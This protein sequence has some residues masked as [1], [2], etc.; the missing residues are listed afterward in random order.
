MLRSISN[1]TIVVATD[2]SSPDQAAAGWGVAVVDASHIERQEEFQIAT[3]HEEVGGHDQTSYMAEL[4]AV[5]RVTWAAMLA[6]KDMVLMIDNRVVSELT[7]DAFNGKPRFPHYGFGHIADIAKYAKR[8]KHQV[9]WIPSHG[10]NADWKPTIEVT[11]Q[12]KRER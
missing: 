1:Q 12:Q 9:S 3:Y 7:R 5:V 10:K 6:K 4:Y 2:G 8:R 11:A